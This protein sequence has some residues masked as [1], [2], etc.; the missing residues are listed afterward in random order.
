MKDYEEFSCGELSHKTVLRAFYTRFGFYPEKI[1]PVDL[2][3]DKLKVLI[4]YK[5][6]S[7][8]KNQE[9]SVYDD[10]TIYA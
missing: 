5:N 6:G 7:L 10:Q 1:K 9:F 2:T 8:T 4:T 3:P